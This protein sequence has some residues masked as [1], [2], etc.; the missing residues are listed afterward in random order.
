MEHSPAQQVKHP[1]PTN[2]TPNPHFI[3]AKASLPLSQQ[4]ATVPCPQPNEFNPHP[5]FLFFNI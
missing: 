1:P 3:E 4:S 5:F 2:S